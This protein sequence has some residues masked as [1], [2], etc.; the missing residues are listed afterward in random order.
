M[1]ADNGNAMHNC[2]WCADSLGKILLKNAFL[3]A[4]DCGAQQ[5]DVGWNQLTAVLNFC[6]TCWSGGRV[7]VSVWATACQLEM[8][9]AWFWINSNQSLQPSWFQMKCYIWK[10]CSYLH[11]ED[12]P[13][14]SIQRFFEQ[15]A[16]QKNHLLCY[17]IVIH[18]LIWKIC[19]K[20]KVPSPHFSEDNE[21]LN[22]H[23][24]FA[25]EN[26]FNSSLYQCNNM[27]LIESWERK[28]Y[29]ELVYAILLSTWL[30][31]IAFHVLP[32]WL[33]TLVAINSDK[34]LWLLLIHARDCLQAFAQCH[35]K[36]LCCLIGI[37]ADT[38]FLDW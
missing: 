32:N 28:N 10:A 18:N 17:Q 15:S 24:A 30:S 27:H 34:Q 1:H 4:V 2:K 26:N 38:L 29:R 20:F 6:V 8:I 3:P 7:Q 5:G 12:K 36:S 14:F 23:R 35:L 37:W 25:R 11:W 33:Q 31:N 19:P 9:L 22:E 21:L 16:T 13:W